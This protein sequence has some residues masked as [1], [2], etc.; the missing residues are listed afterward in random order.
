MSLTLKAYI[1]FHDTL[2]ILDSFNVYFEGLTLYA[3]DILDTI[4]RCEYFKSFSQGAHSPIGYLEYGMRSTIVETCLLYKSVQESQRR[5]FFRS[6]HKL[7]T[8][9]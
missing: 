6:A 7:L 8:E 4:F 2:V 9:L 1:Q 3:S 5:D